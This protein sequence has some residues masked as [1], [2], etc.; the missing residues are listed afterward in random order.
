LNA[1][2]EQVIHVECQEVR[3]ARVLVD[4]VLE[5]LLRSA[6]DAHTQ[7]TDTQTHTHTDRQTDRHTHTHT[8]THT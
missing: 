6:G 5:R 7:H 3:A 2:L 1:P 4:E 8:H